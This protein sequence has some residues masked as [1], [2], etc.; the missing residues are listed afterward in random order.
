MQKVEDELTAL[1]TSQLQQK[2][3]AAVKGIYISDEE[4]SPEEQERH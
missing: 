1:R 2:A 4:T 3:V